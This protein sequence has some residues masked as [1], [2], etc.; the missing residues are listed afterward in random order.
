MGQRNEFGFFFLFGSLVFS[1]GL[2]IEEYTE[3]SGI[4]SL[5]T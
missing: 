3:T 5:K 4:R 1:I 2:R